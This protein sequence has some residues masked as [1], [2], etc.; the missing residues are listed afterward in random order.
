MS[1][2]AGWIQRRLSADSSMST[3][4]SGPLTVP[5]VVGAAV[6]PAPRGHGKL[7]R[8]QEDFV[9]ELADVGTAEAGAV[10]G[11]ILSA[12]TLREL[13]HLRSK[14]FGIVAI[15]HS[16]YEA[17]ERLA[18]LNRHFPTRSPRSGI[19]PFDA[20]AAVDSR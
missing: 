20:I 15:H 13:W 14:V 17:Q 4:A 10:R 6:V 3:S 7:A 19:A 18:R 9:R 8:V 1:R 2:F 5:H 12:R 11:A 16:Q